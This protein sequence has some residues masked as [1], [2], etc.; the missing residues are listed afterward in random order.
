[1]KNVLLIGA[2]NMGFAMLR[3]WIGI[4]GHR[5]AVVE[6]NDVLQKRAQDAG[7]TSYADLSDLPPDYK[8]DILVIA[9][10]P[11]T[12]A[13][14]IAVARD[15]LTL[16]GL[17]ISIAAGVTIN[18]MRQNARED[19]VIIRAMPNTPAAIGEGMIVCCD[20]GNAH[21]ADRERA[22]T[23]LSAVGRVVFVGDEGKMDAVTAVSGS[24]PAYV[25]YFLEAFSAA[26][27]SAGLPPDIA[28][29]LA[30]QT[31]YGA[32]KMAL[33]PKADPST[34]RAQVTSP[35]G[36]TAAGLSVLMDADD[37]LAP[38]L[39]RAVE[40]ARLRSAELGKLA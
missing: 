3:S 2:G 30:K 6:V 13:D 19:A 33:D 32:I 31:L 28:M 37:G 26:G 27:V 23:L 34:L 21:T 22:E 25:F 8:A 12:V 7:A 35:N 20:G 39:R 38:L 14:V 18:G 10:K 16:G 4:A 29:L 11:Q 17:I 5:F 36:T 15:R 40:A 1:M 9:T 24:G